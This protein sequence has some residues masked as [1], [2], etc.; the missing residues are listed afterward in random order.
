MYSIEEIRRAT[1]KIT[2]DYPKEL[3]Q[4]QLK[5]VLSVYDVPSEEVFNQEDGELIMYNNFYYFNMMKDQ[6]DYEKEKKL[7]EQEDVANMNQMQVSSRTI[8]DF[9]NNK[10]GRTN[11]EEMQKQAIGM[12]DLDPND[13][14]KFL[15][16]MAE[17]DEARRQKKMA[18]KKNQNNDGPEFLT[19]PMLKEMYSNTMDLRR[20]EQELTQACMSNRKPGTASQGNLFN[21]N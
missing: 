20:V 14:D 19:H 2:S 9:R 3:K 10:F 4:A 8:R 12:K 21:Q 17:E 6:I 11:C 1:E 15:I 5:K 18:M 16:Q 13:P 7:I